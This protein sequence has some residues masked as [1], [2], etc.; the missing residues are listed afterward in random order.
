METVLPPDLV[1]VILR[2]G[3]TLRLRLPTSA[4]GPMTELC[5]VDVPP[6]GVV[7][8]KFR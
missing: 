8:V 7:T 2:D 4:D 1:E 6:S 3:A 5:S